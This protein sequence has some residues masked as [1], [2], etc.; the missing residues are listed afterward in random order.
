MVASGEPC[1]STAEAEHGQGDKGVGTAES[2]VVRG[3]EII[4]IGSRTDVE[5]LVDAATATLKPDGVVL[6][7]LIEP[8]MH[9]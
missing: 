6:P 3:G 8:H 1:W 7:G 4:G 5:G 2:M 9:I